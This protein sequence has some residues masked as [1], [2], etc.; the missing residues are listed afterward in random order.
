MHVVDSETHPTHKQREAAKQ[1]TEA[2]RSFHRVRCSLGS[3]TAV[4]ETN[5]P[6]SGFHSYLIHSNSFPWQSRVLSPWTKPPHVWAPTRRFL[7]VTQEPCVDVMGFALVLCFLSQ[8]TNVVWTREAQ[9]QG[10][11]SANHRLRF[12]SN[13][14]SGSLPPCTELV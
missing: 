8:L 10:R 5:A 9:I 14:C 13:S 11:S 4:T 1:R 6:L 2:G 12:C 3:H 7:P